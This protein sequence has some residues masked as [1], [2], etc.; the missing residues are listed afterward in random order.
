MGRNIKA[1]EKM[2]IPEEEL[3][4]IREFLN[5]RDGKNYKTIDEMVKDLAINFGIGRSSKI[6]GIENRDFRQLMVEA[7]FPPRGRHFFWE[8]VLERIGF[9]GTIEEYLWDRIKKWNNAEKISRELG[10]SGC[11]VRAKMR[12][13]GIPMPSHGGP[14]FSEKKFPQGKKERAFMEIPEEKIKRMGSK[15]IS[16]LIDCNRAYVSF[17]AR[18]N[19]RR[20]K[21]AHSKKF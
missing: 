7:G 16:N 2:R 17:L 14:R 15:E 19:N 6:L 12:E 10:C 9:K 18:K 21:I 11:L 20:T 4:Q 8:I 5:K 1:E 3:D 13:L